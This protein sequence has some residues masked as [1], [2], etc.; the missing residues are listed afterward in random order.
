MAD[1]RES[2][3]LETVRS[4]GTKIAARDFGLHE[5]GLLIIARK[6]IQRIDKEIQEYEECIAA[7]EKIQELNERFCA[8]NTEKREKRLEKIKLNT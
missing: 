3:I 2:R 6:D 4:K 1:S 5:A 8:W 7:L